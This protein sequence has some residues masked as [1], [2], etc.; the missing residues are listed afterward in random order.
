VNKNA[1]I[2]K[3]KI[4]GKNS[5]PAAGS[6]LRAK[7][8]DHIET[9]IYRLFGLKNRVTPGKLNAAG[10]H[11]KK[12]DWSSG[13]LEYEP[14]PDAAVHELGHLVLAA[15]GLGLGAI[16]RDMDSQFGYSQSVNGYM[17]QKQSIFETMPMGAEQ[18]LRRVLGLPAN[19]SC[20]AVKPG[21]APRRELESGRECANRVRLKNGKTVDLIRCSKNLD[22]AAL[23]RIDMILSGELIFSPLRGWIQS[24]SIDA[25]INRRA[26]LKA[27]R[28]Q[29]AS[30]S[31]AA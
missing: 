17:K 28:A 14:N 22:A 9:M 30:L 21:D 2:Q 6:K 16:Q 15:R 29:R 20:V 11:I 4:F 7:H 3:T 12:P 18:K 27:N 1:K 19:R 26:R 5:S 24:N 31:A 13:W 10:K 25:K 8:M 23:E